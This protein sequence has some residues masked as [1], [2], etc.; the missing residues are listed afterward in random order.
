MA[1][2]KSFDSLAD[3]LDNRILGALAALSFTH[4]T[5]VQ[6][7][8]I[9]LALDG[10]DILAR[11]RTGSGKTLA[12]IIPIVHRIIKAKAAL[13]G[14]L[15]DPDLHAIR[16]LV[17]VPTREL[18]EQVAS[19]F[20]ALTNGLG[21]DDLIKVCNIAGGDQTKGKGTGGNEKLQR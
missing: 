18:S 2:A 14:G 20:R 4:P 21:D 16:A 13:A 15:T 6:A 12:Y 7:A 1:E 8:A 9:P 19:H 3:V 11:A 17:L 5:P 10:K